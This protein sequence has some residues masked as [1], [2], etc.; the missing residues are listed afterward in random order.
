MSRVSTVRGLALGLLVVPLLAGCL[1]GKDPEV[2]VADPTDG[3]STLSIHVIDALSGA[4]LGKAELEIRV[5]GVGTLR[6][7]TDDDGRVAVNLRPAPTCSVTVER[8]G[9]QSG[10]AIL[11]CSKDGAF[12]ILLKPLGTG[13]APTLIN[14]SAALPPTPPG[15]VRLTGTLLDGSSA[16]P[17]VGAKV[18][19]DPPDG[20]STRTNAT[21]FFTF[22]APPG[23]HVLQF[24]ADCLV[25]GEFEFD[26][27]DDM[28][29]DLSMQRDSE[30]PGTPTGL[31]ATA[32]PG[33]GM[34]TLSW[35][36]LPGASGF[37]LLRNGQPFHRLGH[38][39]AYGVP[40]AVASDTFALAA[41]NKCGHEG[42]STATVSAAPFPGAAPSV[43]APRQL[44]VKVLEEERAAFAPN[45]SALAPRRWRTAEGTGNCCEN[46]IATSPSGRI[47]DQGGS[48][49]SFSDDEGQTWQGVQS[50]LI[51]LAGEG[52][53]TAAPDGDIVA[54]DWATY[55]ADTAFAY[56]YSAATKTW[57]TQ[58]VTSEMPAYDRPWISVIKGPFTVGDLVVPYVSVVE[59]G[60]GVKDPLLISLDGLTYV[61][62][63]SI[64]QVG[65]ATV[66][67]RGF[68]TTPDANRDWLGA[69]GEFGVVPLDNGVGI[70]E[71]QGAMKGTPTW[72]GVNLPSIPGEILRIDSAGAWHSAGVDGA[73][74]TYAISHDAG[75]HWET[76]GFTLP[77]DWSVGEWDFRVNAHLDQ[78]V[79]AVNADIEGNV[80]QAAVRFTGLDG[81][82]VAKEL[83]YVGGGDGVFGSGVAEQGNR[84]DFMTLGFLPDGRIV[85]SAGDARTT[86][87]F[88][89]IEL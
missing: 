49:L 65:E 9:Y 38:S 2:P 67:L 48:M 39:L 71:R 72:R 76:T 68:T 18:R 47:L 60:I 70:M 46:Y 75:A 77:S 12:R 24:D 73:R 57:H 37:V 43:V 86:R 29:L 40:G 58:P 17:I 11:N 69:M 74:L 59:G 56:R 66:D 64:L 54:F 19:L 23:L 84:F 16:A 33:P 45:G 26:L 13:G 42:A 51:L 30:P 82:P 35:S 83:L 5:A 87:P 62:S 20:P 6:K 1:Q 55:N 28:A 31:R 63:N 22:T 21:G 53:V 36:D 52:S 14:G 50:P 25:A 10:G 15:H 32:G 27:Q 41:T 8:S 88:M 7:T 89:A 61:P 34:V 79:F 3:V 85:M 4:G 81:V 78:A 80:Q 44:S